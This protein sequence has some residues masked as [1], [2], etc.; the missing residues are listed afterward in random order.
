MIQEYILNIYKI[1]IE[2]NYKNLH[3]FFK[4]FCTFYFKFYT[5]KDG[6]FYDRGDSGSYLHL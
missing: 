5:K 2:S 4:F 1:Q 3:S 6:D